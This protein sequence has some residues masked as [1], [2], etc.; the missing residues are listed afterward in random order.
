MMRKVLVIG[1]VVT[2][3]CSARA[4]LPFTDNFGN[5]QPANSDSITGFWSQFPGSQLSTSQITEDVGVPGVTPTNL[6]LIA[7]ASN[8][9]DVFGTAPSADFNFFTA[10]KTFILN[11]LSFTPVPS[12]IPGT[13]QQFRFAVQSD[14]GTTQA[15]SFDAV[16]LFIDAANDVRLGFKNT[17]NGNGDTANSLVN[18]HIASGSIS[19]F[20]LT[21]NSTGYQLTVFDPAG[22]VNFNGNYSQSGAQLLQSSWV[23][24]G[25]STFSLGAFNTNTLG[26]VQVNVDQLTVV[27]EPSATLLTIVGAISLTAIFVLRVRKLG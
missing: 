23:G 20:S 22:N 26:T 3:A 1:F 25:N 4:S 15:G 24:N 11:G 2:L 14:G 16:T 27:P 8:E 19:G 12:S 5:G 7:G 17:G 21:L 18:T 10:P 6:H 13:A 9:A